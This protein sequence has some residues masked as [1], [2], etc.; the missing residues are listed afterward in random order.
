MKAFINF[1]IVI[2]CLNLHVFA[3][4]KEKKEKRRINIERSPEQELS[5]S[6]R[7]Y[8]PCIKSVQFHPNG[9]E[10]AIPILSLN[11]GD[12]L[13]L[14][15]DDLRA[16]NR[17]FYYTIEHCTFDWKSS[18]LSTLEYIEG[19]TEDRIF[20]YKSS[21]NTLQSYT[22][23]Q[24]SFPNEGSM[25]PKL[26]GNYLLKVYEDA[27]KSRLILTR[28]FYVY[29]QEV[30]LDINILPSFDVSK[31]KQNQKLNVEVNLEQLNINNPYQDIK[32]VV[33]QNRRDDM[34]EVLS[35]PMFVKENQLIYNNNK[36]LDFDGG[37]EFHNLDIRSFRL[38]SGQ[39]QNSIK[40]SLRTLILIP[41]Q[42]L[43]AE[44]YS[45]SFDEDGKYFIRNNDFDDSEI[46][47][48][49]ARIE[50]TLKTAPPSKG[51]RLF[52]VGLFNNFETNSENEMIYDLE[53]KAWKGF[54]KLKQGLYHYTYKSIDENGK[55]LVNKYNGHHFETGNTYDVFTY[56][57]KPA[58]RWDE[59]VGY[60][61]VKTANNERR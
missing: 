5:Y 57:R 22:H 15:F 37:N 9:E 46:E 56:Y 59:L 54:L 60:G 44:T 6:D 14:S 34:Q 33:K 27:D 24:L 2:C 39:I 21:V 40:D 26:S 51:E 32:V 47:G 35:K 23:Y 20:D 16:D 8:L 10:Q 1:T 4:K 19:V 29:R 31:R 28:K 42:D 58:T 18:N 53:K 17:T 49:Y 30:G 25:L 61:T 52:I 45:F 12:Q 38:L 48:D 13:F 11:S 43:S 7:D 41:D 50:F 36:T 3:Q 55:V